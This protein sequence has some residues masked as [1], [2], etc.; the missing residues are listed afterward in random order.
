MSESVLWV[1]PAGSVA[2]DAT[3]QAVWATMPT[4][5]RQLVRVDAATDRWAARV[6]AADVETL[7]RRAGGRVAAAR[8]FGDDRPVSRAIALLRH[9]DQLRFD[10]H[11][12]SEL[13]FDADGII[14][15]G[16]RDKRVF[17]RVDPAVIGLI[18]LA[19]TD[20]ILLARNAHRGTFWSLIAGYVDPGENLEEAFAREAYEETG[21]RIHSVRYWGSQ[22]WAASGS[23]MVGF[24]ARTDD[25][26]AV[27]PTDGE[28]AEIRWVD[29]DELGHLPLARPGSI[30][31]AMI[32]EW[33]NSR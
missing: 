22:P 19:G 4:R 15:R 32:I 9:R 23:L 2:V 24:T 27:A 21:R 6:D 29:R 14:A 7:A 12:G 30:A 8:E 31:H 26:E 18:E 17:P 3:G 1:D 20:R 16:S 10:P 11:D 28:L 33:R 25:P 5:A 13:I